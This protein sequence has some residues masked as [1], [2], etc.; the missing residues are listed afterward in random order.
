YRVA[1]TQLVFE[2]GVEQGQVGVEAVM[3][4]EVGANLGVGAFLGLQVWVANTLGLALAGD[5]VDASMQLIWIRCFKALAHAAFKRPV[6]VGVP[7]QVGTWA[8]VAAEGLMI[9]VT[10]PDSQRE[11][12]DDA[13]FVF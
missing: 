10:G 5:T 12:V 1:V 8:D 6:V 2:L 13:P 4:V 9:V 7:D 11:A 3:V